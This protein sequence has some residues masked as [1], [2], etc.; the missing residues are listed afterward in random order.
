MDGA[1]VAV[2][3]RISLD[4]AGNRF[5]WRNGSKTC[6]YGLNRIVN[7][8]TAG[9]VVLVEGE[10]DAQTLW[11]HG[12][13]A[14]GLPGAA[15]W[16]EARDATL[17]A[18][19]ATIYIVIEPDRGGDTVIARLHHSSIA[20]RVRLVRLRGSKDASA[21][22]LADPDG[23]SAEFQRALNDAEP[24][25]AVVDRGAAAEATRER[26]AAGDLIFESDIL[27]RF[28]AELPRAGLVGEDRSA[29]IL[30]LALT[31]RLF[32]RPVSVAV[33]GPSSGGKSY[34]VEIVLRFFPTAA[35]WE[36]T[37]MSDRALAYS[38]EDFRHRHLVI[39]E[40]AGMASDI[41]SYLIRSLLSEGRIRYELVEK[42]K[43]GMIARV[44]EKDGPTGL[45]VTTT[46]PR[47]H[48]ENETRLLSLAV[49]DTPQQT[50]AI[51]QALARGTETARAVDYGQWQAL[52]KWLGV[53][54]RR[55][56]VPFAEKL[57]GLVPPIAV[58]L[59]RDFGLLLALIQ[60]HALLHRELRQKDGQG[61]ILAMLDDYAAVRN[62]V[63]DLFAEGVDAT[64]KPETRETVAAAGAL[65]KARDKEDASLADIAKVL[66]LDRSATSRRVAEAKSRGYLV[67]NETRKGRPARLALGDPM[68]AEIEILPTPDRLADCCTVAAL[69]EGI[70]T[71][72][73]LPDYG[74]E[75]AEI[76]I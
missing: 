68:P 11:Y 53:G 39:Y 34:I 20:A 18:E 49:K 61:R 62:L 50:A 27:G 7:A 75:L 3:F 33:K 76:E 63:A 51:L 5:R 59:R 25:Q 64:V 66:T 26:E 36:R 74:A 32:G 40:A 21:L 45:I 6:L 13:A 41:A 16:N 9:Y 37:A 12:F 28:V 2:R 30:F 15:N 17:L 46:A 47:L 70:E 29:K 43:N 69:Q 4:G 73:P 10:S 19:L 72:S 14:L 31:T 56:V 22:Y 24:Y 58:R 48:P 1:E 38:D 54:E 71:P 55:V 52:Q 42:T 44:I 65:L 60:A 35:Y 8:R 57:A 23:F 67:N